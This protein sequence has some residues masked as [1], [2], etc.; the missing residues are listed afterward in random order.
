MIIYYVIMIRLKTI[1]IAT[2]W[3][4]NYPILVIPFD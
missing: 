2:Q 4:H 1:F 3:Y